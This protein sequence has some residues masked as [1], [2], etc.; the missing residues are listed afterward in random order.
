M[1]NVGKPELKMF[2]HEYIKE[3]SSQLEKEEIKEAINNDTY[4]S[5]MEVELDKLKEEFSLYVADNDYEIISL[6]ADNLD[7][8]KRVAK[9]YVDVDLED[10]LINEYLQGILERINCNE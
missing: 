5:Q 10:D 1:I 3:N 8:I 4:S 9:R 2:V 6:N 7:R